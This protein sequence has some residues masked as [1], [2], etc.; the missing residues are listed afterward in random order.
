MYLMHTEQTYCHIQPKSLSTRLIYSL[1]PYHYSGY[2]L[3]TIT[4]F[5]F[6]F[7]HF[8][9]VDQPVLQ[10]VRKAS[11][12]WL[13]RSVFYC[14]F[15]V[16]ETNGHTNTN[17]HVEIHWPNK[18]IF[19][20]IFVR[21]RKW[22]IQYQNHSFR[23]NLLPGNAKKPHYIILNKHKHYNSYSKNISYCH[24]SNYI[25]CCSSRAHETQTQ[26]IN[27]T[28]THSKNTCN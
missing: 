6:H 22:P 3:I 21:D 14:D 11:I 26:H 16:K 28:K 19:L 25:I 10:N 23:R 7:Q 17:Y 24:A 2:K 12:P 9:S 18:A 8:V 15:V 13:M 4:Y 27:N 1:W 5:I 20:W